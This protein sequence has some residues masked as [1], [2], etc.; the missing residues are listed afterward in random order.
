MS[1]FYYEVTV[2]ILDGYKGDNPQALADMVMSERMDHNEE[3]GFG[4]RI[5]WAY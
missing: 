3:Y 1:K 2:E 4:Y 5:E